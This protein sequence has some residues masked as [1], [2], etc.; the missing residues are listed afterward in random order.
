MTAYELRNHLI[1]WHG[2][3][4]L[5]ADHGTLVTVHDIEH[6]TASSVPDHEHER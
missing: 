2:I 4:L 3:R 1:H 5:G 6:R